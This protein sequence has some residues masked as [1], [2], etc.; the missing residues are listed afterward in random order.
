MPD[1]DPLKRLR[2][3]REEQRR[4]VALVPERDRLIRRAAAE[5]HSQRLIAKAAG[6]TRA[7]V[8]QILD[9]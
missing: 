6:L 8:G 3:I 1:V 7:R 2:E 4:A 5:K 9:E